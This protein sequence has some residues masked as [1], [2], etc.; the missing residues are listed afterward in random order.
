MWFLWFEQKFQVIILDQL[1]RFLR[2]LFVNVLLMCQLYLFFWV[3]VLVI[4]GR[5]WISF[6][7]SVQGGLMIIM[8]VFVSLFL[9][10]RFWIYRLVCRIFFGVSCF[11]EISYFVRLLLKWLVVQRFFSECQNM[12]VFVGYLFSVVM[13]VLVMCVS[14]FL[15]LNG[16]LIS[17]R[18][19][20]FGGGISDLSVL[21]LLC[22]LI[23]ICLLCLQCVFSVLLFWGWS[24]YK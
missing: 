7:F 14:L 13:M 19:C 20:F 22:C 4:Q 12:N 17:I 9:L 10:V 1:V 2:F 5:F 24:L 6:F 15:F 3:S 11:F 16:G 8:L 21:Q 18:L 23:F